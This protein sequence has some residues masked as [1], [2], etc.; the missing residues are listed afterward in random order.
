MKQPRLSENHI[1]VLNN[2]IYFDSVFKL[3]R[4]SEVNRVRI[5]NQ[6]KAVSNRSIR[7]FTVGRITIRKENEIFNY[8]FVLIY[9]H[10]SLGTY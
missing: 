1:T 3:L 6:H 10:A 9:Y 8:N 7:D 2:V 4:L 5:I